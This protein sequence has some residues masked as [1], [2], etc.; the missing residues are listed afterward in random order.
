M[1]KILVAGVV[2]LGACAG[3]QESSN[4]ADTT[5][6]PITIVD[7]VDKATVDSM[8]AVTPEGPASAK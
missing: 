1:R 2:F 7:S 3:K 6:T 8:K 4:V 5:A